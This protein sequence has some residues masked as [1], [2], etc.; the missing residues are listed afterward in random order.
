MA[1]IDSKTLPAT[2]LFSH[3]SWLELPCSWGPGHGSLHLV[4]YCGELWRGHPDKEWRNKEQ[5]CFPVQS[6]KK[7][8]KN[9]ENKTYSGWFQVV[10]QRLADD[11]CV[12]HGDSWAGEILVSNF[13]LRQKKEQSLLVNTSWIIL[14]DRLP[15]KN[16]RILNLT[17]SSAK[18]ERLKNA[19]R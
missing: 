2:E 6:E 5:S 10:L 13:G 12:L 15:P 7:K 19:P 3:C 11:S 16:E 9:S 14:F 17:S 8:K 18:T 4:K 1:I